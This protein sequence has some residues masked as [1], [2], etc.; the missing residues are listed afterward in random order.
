MKFSIALLLLLCSSVGT[1]KELLMVSSEYA[2]YVMQDEQGNVTGLMP[3]L[4]HAALPNF[5]SQISFQLVP[6]KRA[7]SLVEQ[8]KAFAAFP[9]S[10]NDDRSKRFHF[11]EPVLDFQPG[12]FYRKANFP[13]GFNWGS[14]G[15]LRQYR[16]ASVTGYAP[17]QVF[18]KHQVPTIIVSNELAALTMIYGNRADFFLLDN[19]AAWHLIRTH[20]QRNQDDFASATNASING[21][22]YLMVSRVQPENLALLNKFN[23]GM[24][25]LKESGQ[26]QAILQRYQEPRGI[27]D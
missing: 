14:I 5:E 4:I 2:P 21:R 20:F 19:R 8:G 12:L 7:E 17:N 10:K 6:W 22:Y 16:I 1:A 13:E 25:Q 15:Q 9:Y 18:A 24:R 11:S 23:N 27:S 3:D 26:Y